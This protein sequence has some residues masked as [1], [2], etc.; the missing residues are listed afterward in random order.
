MQTKK[1]EALQQKLSAWAE[2]KRYQFELKT[3]WVTVDKI[4]NDTLDIILES[5][6][7][8]LKEEQSFAEESYPLHIHF[9]DD[10]HLQKVGEFVKEF[11]ERF[12]EYLERNKKG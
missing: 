3:P 12:Y 11:D 6:V 10:D 9:M 7:V 8:L 5:K 2:T 4:G 1:F